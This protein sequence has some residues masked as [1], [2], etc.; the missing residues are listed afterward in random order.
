MKHRFLVPALAGIAIASTVPCTAQEV[1]Q[2]DAQEETSPDA[3][4]PSSQD[5]PEDTKLAALEEAAK[6][7]V[8]AFNQRDAAAIA[9]TYLPDGEL[10]LSAGDII[11]GREA[12]E[13]YYAGLFEAA[14]DDAPQAAVEADEVRFVTPAIAIESGHFHLTATSGEVSSHRYTAVLVQQDDGSWLAATVRG[15]KDDTAL[16]DEKLLALDWIVGDWMIENDGSRTYIAFNWSDDGPFIDARAL[17]E[18]AGVEST[19]S[20][21]RIGWDARRDSFVS[22][23]FDAQGGYSF[24]EWTE[25]G[26]QGYLIRSLGV[27]ADGEPQRGTLVLE[28]ADDGQSFT[29][30]SRDKVI[31]SEVLADRSLKVVKR[32]PAPKAASAE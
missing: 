6:S 26:D 1:A 23:H 24:N 20:T 4:E 15:E 25:S 21:L 32:P 5:A 28:L 11:T 2:N 13:D 16:P 31:G 12:I 27:T 30:S 7:L 3:A 10:T 14:G 8:E 22:W 19:A 17:T 18:E 29:W 9:A